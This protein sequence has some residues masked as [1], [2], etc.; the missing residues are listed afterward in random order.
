[1]EPMP[2][3]VEARNLNHCTAWEVPQAHTFRMAKI[4]KPEH[5]NCW[6]DVEKLELSYSAGWDVKQYNSLENS[7]D[8][9]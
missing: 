2:P 7:M 9:S 4:R 8:V 1:M 5:T 3:A 6:Q